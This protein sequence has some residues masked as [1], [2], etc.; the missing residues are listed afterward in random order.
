MVTVD[1]PDGDVRDM[2]P[3][4]ESLTHFKVIRDNLFMARVDLKVAEPVTREKAI[5]IIERT[6]F[7]KELS[8]IQVAPDMVEVLGAGGNPRGEGIETF[9]DPA[10]IPPQDRIISYFLKLEHVKA[11]VAQ[12]RLM[13]AFVRV[14]PFTSMLVA[15][16]A[17]ALWLI[18]RASVVRQVL[19]MA[20]TLDV[21][22]E[23]P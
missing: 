4:Y 14:E 20:A 21:A 13:R 22:P 12:D 3:L 23:Q 11:A 16:N 2:L 18:G 15:G 19:A 10:Q 6:F 9:F 5:E 8:I 7:G 1:F 17:N